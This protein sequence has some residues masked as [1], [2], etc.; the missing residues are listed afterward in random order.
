MSAT[1]GRFLAGTLVLAALT[2]LVNPAAGQDKARMPEQFSGYL[3][4]YTAKGGSIT[5]ITVLQPTPRGK[6]LQ[7]T[8]TLA[9]GKT[10]KFIVKD[11]DDT[12]EMD[13]RS[14]LTDDR[15]RD[16]LV[17]KEGS[18][19]NGNMGIRVAVET[20]GKAATKVTFTQKQKK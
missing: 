11:G 9:V 4:K 5:Q 1:I 2:T 20:K 17:Q 8:W 3:M 19:L 18:T 16:M 12:V 13:A 15:T 6:V 14:V 10:T 7:Q